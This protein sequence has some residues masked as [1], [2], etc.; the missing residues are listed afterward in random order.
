[1]FRSQFSCFLYRE[2]CPG[3]QLE[4][5]F[6][7]NHCSS[8]YSCFHFFIALIPTLLL[9]Y[10]FNAW[11]FTCNLHKNRK[12]VISITV[13]SLA[14]WTVGSFL[15]RDWNW[16]SYISGFGGKTLSLIAAR[17]LLD[18]WIGG[19]VRL[20]LWLQMPCSAHFTLLADKEEDDHIHRR[21]SKSRGQM[22]GIPE[23][24]NLFSIDWE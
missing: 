3:I 10:L 1:M 9:V 11:V 19:R 4:I 12:L 16:V 17:Y 24:L 8:H 22:E 18:G 14:V 21:N 2:F 23:R 6:S 7:V 13:A 15:P 5:L 20:Q